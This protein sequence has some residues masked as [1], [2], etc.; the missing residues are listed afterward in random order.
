[1]DRLT[2]V[3]HAIENDCQICPIGSFK[4]T[5]EHQ[6]RRNEAFRGLDR[7]EGMRLE[8]YL[9]FRNVQDEAKR[10][11]LDLPTAP[12]N[13]RFLE[14]ASEDQPRGSWSLQPD[15]RRESV[16]VRSLQW[17]GYQFFHK[18]SSNRFGA[19]Y[20]GDGLKNLEIHFIV[21]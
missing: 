19:V 9:H 10:A 20:I 14:S 11:E 4:M 3:V 2:T 18:L 6:V 16:M 12:F 5:P 21:Q 8:N 13:E 7:A 15:E 17:P 1:L